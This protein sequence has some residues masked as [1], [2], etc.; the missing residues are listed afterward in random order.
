[1]EQS[2]GEQKRESGI[3]QGTPSSQGAKTSQRI[4]RTMKS[5]VAE[6]IRNQNETKVSIAVAEEKKRRAQLEATKAEQGG[7]T[8][9]AP[10]KRLSRFVVVLIIMFILGLLAAL[11]VFVLPQITKINL[12]K[13]SLP[14]FPQKETPQ[15]IAPTSTE[16]TLAPSLISAQKEHRFNTSEEARGQIMNKMSA[17][18]G[19]SGERGSIA[20]IL[21]TKNEGGSLRELTANELLSFAGTPTPDILTR[22]L[23][24]TFMVG[25]T[26]TN[27]GTIPFIILRVSE[28][29]TAFAGMLE[30]EEKL[31]VL[32]DNLFGTNTGRTLASGSKFR[33]I[34]VSGKDARMITSGNGSSVGYIFASPTT[35]IIAGSEDTLSVLLASIK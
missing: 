15:T 27:A 10:A 7:P 29:E 17:L 21:F 4:V 31:P 22:S 32:F 19:E 23:E 2:S 26:T 35:I 20:N 5:D 3:F 14:T 11:Y 24:K 28:Y 33:D 25:I 8:Q 6:A 18:L 34:T 1:M 13:I 12:P 30:W 16:P 9:E